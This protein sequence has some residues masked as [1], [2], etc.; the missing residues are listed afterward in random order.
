MYKKSP[1]FTFFSVIEFCNKDTMGKNEILYIVLIL[2]SHFLNE[3]LFLEMVTLI[4]M[5]WNNV[6]SI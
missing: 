6:K 2:L 4:K 3:E 1:N 5:N